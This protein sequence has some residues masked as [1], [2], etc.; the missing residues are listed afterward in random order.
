MA[1]LEIPALYRLDLGSSMWGWHKMSDLVTAVDLLLECLPEEILPPLEI[2]IPR[3]T[4]NYIQR[5]KGKRL[6]KQYGH[7]NSEPRMAWSDEIEISFDDIDKVPWERPN[8]FVPAKWGLA[9]VATIKEHSNALDPWSLFE[10][11]SNCLSER[12]KH[13]LQLRLGKKTGRKEKLEHV[14]KMFQTSR[15]RVRQIEAK[16]IRRLRNAA[17]ASLQAEVPLSSHPLDSSKLCEFEFRVQDQNSLSNA[18]IETVRQ[19]R[20]KTL[21]DMFKL[22]NFG[23]SAAR[24]VSDIMLGRGI[25]LGWFK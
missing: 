7:L 3:P 1:R 18:G 11:H 10:T 23:K 14:A 8:L 25:D 15:E 6:L 12:E 4:P 9:V 21:V 5:L 20:E 2:T 17:T 13:V 16:A 22:R 24:D 19:L